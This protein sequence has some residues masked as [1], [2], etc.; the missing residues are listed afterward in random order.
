VASDQESRNIKRPGRIVSAFRV[1][2]GTRT[3]PA[4]LAAD[5]AEWEL[6]LTGV[7]DRFGALLARQ[8]K[9]EKRK[10]EQ[11]LELAP[12]DQINGS[13]LSSKAELYARANR[14]RGHNAKIRVAEGGGLDVVMPPMN[15]ENSEEN[16]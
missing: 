2:M 3:T 7:L 13:P 8:A 10:V 9:A 16:P 12:P 4:Q 15:F 11:Q 14:L 6:V 1:L 5:W